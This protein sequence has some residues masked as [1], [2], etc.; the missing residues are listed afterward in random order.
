MSGNDSNRMPRSAMAKFSRKRSVDDFFFPSPIMRIATNKLPAT[1][2]I[3]INTSRL[4]FRISTKDNSAI[5]PAMII[6]SFTG[7][8]EFTVVF[9]QYHVVQFSINSAD[10]VNVLLAIVT[11][12]D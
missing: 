9:G 5:L 2:N 6:V 8:E 3:A 12:P 1:P 4:N 10:I 11:R 7:R